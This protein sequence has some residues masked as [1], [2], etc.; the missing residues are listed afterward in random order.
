MQ[1]SHH[2][3][4]DIEA[5]AT[6][7]HGVLGA[8]G[9]DPQR[10]G[11]AGT[12]QRAA[13]SLTFLTSGYAQNLEDIV[14]GALYVSNNDEMII[15]QNIELYSLCEHHVLPFFGRVHIGY[16][17]N[18]K[19]IGVSKLA[20]IVDLY[21]RRL[22]IQEQLTQQIAE[23]VRETTEARGVGVV[24]EARH[25]CIM[26]RGVQKQ[27]SVMKTSMMLGVFRSNSA[28]RAEFLSTL[29]N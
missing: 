25:L 16:L 2:K 20:R 22:Q 17:P 4:V 1:N 7:M 13:K 26:M 8:I 19:V 14:R 24:V 6:H 5:L 21:A 9:E 23:A 28:T 29:S 3:T 27:N 18:G 12:P 15:L 10:K 11:L